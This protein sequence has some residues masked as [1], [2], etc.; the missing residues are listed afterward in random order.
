VRLAAKRSPP[1]FGG[2]GLIDGRRRRIWGG[3]KR[4]FEFRVLSGIGFGFRFE[5]CVLFTCVC[6]CGVGG[7]RRCSPACS[8]ATLARVGDTSS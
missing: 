6:M 1:A 5:I 7:T 4:G 3:S 8:P 2:A